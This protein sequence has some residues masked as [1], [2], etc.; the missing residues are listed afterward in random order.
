MALRH[1]YLNN[2]ICVGISKSHYTVIITEPVD[3]CGGRGTGFRNLGGNGFDQWICNNMFSVKKK[4]GLLR[5]TPN[6][7]RLYRASSLSSCPKV[8]SRSTLIEA[9]IKVYYEVTEG[10]TI[11]K[12]TKSI[13]KSIQKRCQ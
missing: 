10:E 9:W 7:L 3:L 13:C 8:L 4:F 11:S 12:S 5:V 6:K 2:P 1:L